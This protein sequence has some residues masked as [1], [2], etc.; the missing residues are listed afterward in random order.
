[1]HQGTLRLFRLVVAVLLVAGLLM[2][3]AGLA[4]LGL[5][6]APW[7]D[8][9]L[10]AGGL[11]LAA[12]AWQAW[13]M[14]HTRDAMGHLSAELTLR[15]R[16]AQH[17]GSPVMVT[18]SRLGVLWCNQA[19]ERDT[20][21]SL[22]D[23]QGR[24]PG[25]LLRS[26]NADPVTVERI[27]DAVRHH[28]DIDIELLHRYRDG[29]DRWVRV[30][31]SCQRDAAGLP[32][33]FV[34]VL[35][36]IDTQVRTREALRRALRHQGSLMRSL[37]EYVIVAETDR[38][39]RFT[40]VNQRFQE[41]SGYSETQLLGQR[42]RLLG[43][44]FHPPAFWQDMW[45]RIGRGLPWQGEICNRDA[46]GRLFWVHSLVAPL[47]GTDGQ[48]D[49]FV[50]IQSDI[51]AHRMAQ[52]ELSQSEALLRSTSQLAGVG[53]WS[54]LLEGGELQ[55]TP[56]ARELLGVQEGELGSLEDL[57]RCFA[58][59]SRLAIRAQLR[60][61]AEG[62]R[63]EVSVLAP[64]RPMGLG[65][66]RWVRL[67]ATLRAEHAESV[68]R[69]RMPGRIIGAV[70]DYS[71]QMQAQQ[72]IREEQRIL[73]SA[74]DAVGEAFALFDA[75][76]RLVYCNDA[77]SAWLPSG[78][79]GREALRHDDVLRAVAHSGAFPEALGREA[80]WVKE[81]LNAPLT[82][83]TDRVRQAA[84]GRWFRF[85]DR[86]T[87]DG[88]RVVLRSDVTE[89]QT[90]LVRADAASVSKGQFLANMS[91]EI[92]TP[93]NAVM[94]MLQLLGQTPLA[95]EQADMV[96]KSLGAARSLLEIVNDILDFSKIEA[97][98]MELHAVPFRLSDL[99]RELEVILAGALGHKPL[100][101][102]FDTDPALPDVL[103]G[104]PVRLK[105]VLINLGGNAIK[106]TAE[107]HVRLHWRQLARDG[108]LLH[109]CFEV[110]DTGIGIA[111]EQQAR[112]FD[113][114]SQGEASTARRFGG[115]G[116]GLTISQRLVAMMGGQ[117]ALHSEPGQGSTFSFDVALPLGDE[118][119]VPV[120]TPL[121]GST[122]APRLQGLRLLLAE[123]N[124]LNQEVA[125]A[126]LRRE[127]AEVRL[128][129]NGRQ[130]VEALAADPQGFDAVLMDMQM[131]ELDGLQATEQIR[132]RLELRMLPVLAMTANAMQQDRERCLAAGMNAHIGKP[133]DIEQVVAQILHFTRPDAASALA[134]TPQADAATP[135]S[136]PWRED[137]EALRRLGGNA[138]LLGQLRARFPAT[139][140][141]CMERAQACALRTDWSAVADALHQ[142]KGAAGVVGT[143]RLAQACAGLE[144]RLRADPAAVRHGEVRPWLDALAESL[145]TSVQALAVPAAPP[146]EE[147]TG[148]GQ[149]SDLTA[150]LSALRA[151][152]APLEAADMS[153]IDEHEQ[154]LQR[155]PA[156]RGER[157]QVFNQCMESM[158]FPAAARACEVLLSDGE[159]G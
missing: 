65:P 115:S 156:A 157:F 145:A 41:I 56:E 39:G 36:D 125:L 67:V 110:E 136:A 109:L 70:Q 137:T 29:K 135:A 75:D 82:G 142:L 98:K 87:A 22:A 93:I 101:L 112:I 123:D 57:W 45:T 77:Y 94:G 47:V 59:G 46:Q 27:R 62:R 48:I 53:G 143:D 5:R 6:Q 86:V 83:E 12:G 8:A 68:G 155:H 85:I 63:V 92:R 107:G 69:M 38:E 90:A 102:V 1:M 2:V 113:S 15:E 32:V 130:A 25:P 95:P 152:K 72:R 99:R 151:L 108:D 34:S 10:T 100:A 105:Q 129:E 58:T 132:E 44:G 116:L 64:L 49:K 121:V 126:M 21:Y 55:M 141:E 35:I 84:D 52:I 37:D 146:P 20:G 79:D 103:V 4:M 43:S 78:R 80:D 140:S 24:R 33:G 154:W 88:H 9:L 31:L 73:H 16:A 97:G 159:P 153:V 127:G 114:F 18:D 42:F 124:A 131:P 50:C 91:H 104:D 60:E 117:I 138:A 158:D 147:P 139:A 120:H 128:A 51:T 119:D 3:L 96:G 7:S 28:S 122:G 71:A 66:Q 30:L 111:P 40:R 14:R 54:V 11:M 89:L 74:M 61:L 81:V 106:F 133:F 76:Q 149:S 13:L 150:C 144:R 26:P 148:T 134:L 17:A 118:A 19:F 23:V